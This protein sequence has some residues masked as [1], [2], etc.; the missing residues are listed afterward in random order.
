MPLPRLRRL[1]RRNDDRTLR[2][3]PPQRTSL[4][5]RILAQSLLLTAFTV[6]TLSLLSVIVMH[7]MTRNRALAQLSSDVVTREMLLSRAIQFDRERTA[8]LTNRLQ[9]S[10]A[11]DVASLRGLFEELVRE[12]VPVL[13]LTIVD[14]TGRALA[15]AGERSAAR[16]AKAQGTSVTPVLDRHG[17]WTATDVYAALPRGGTLAVR[18]ASS[19]LLK[20]L[21]E[22]LAPGDSSELSLLRLEDGVVSKPFI[23]SQRPVGRGDALPLEEYPVPAALHEEAGTYAGNDRFGKQIFAAYRTVPALGWSLFLAIDTSEAMAG[24]ERFA[25]VML[26]LDLFMIALS[27]VLGLALARQLSEPILALAAKMRLLRPGRW[28]FRRSV[29][30]GDEAETLDYAAAELTAR[31]RDTYEHLEEEVSERT[32]ELRRQY[33]LDRTILERIEYAVLVTDAAGSIVQANPAAGRLLVR[34]PADLLGCDAVVALPLRKEEESLGGDAHPIRRALRRKERMLATH[35]DRLSILV[36]GHA[37]PVAVDALPL[38]RGSRFEGMIVIVRDVQ[39][40]KRVEEMK[41]D[42][43][44]LASH[45]LRTPLS[46]LR[47]YVELLRGERKPSLSPVQ[48][49]FVGE[50]E[51]ASQR[52]GE[53]LDEL[54]RITRLE[55]GDVHV[56]QKTFD[57]RALLL[58]LGREWEDLAVRK[59][60]MC[61]IDAPSH[62]VRIHSD[63][64]LLRLV[65]QNLFSNALKYSPNG[66]SIRVQLQ[67][68]AGSVAVSMADAG[69]GIPR[70]EQANVFRKFFRAK[71]ARRA[72][73][74]GTGIGLYLTRTIVENLGGKISFDS[75]GKGTT[76]TVKLPLKG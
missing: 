47:W 52:M 59:G 44:S 56:E 72:D 71:N 58:S 46:S 36:D 15:G 26:A 24:W 63:P 14:E 11:Q 20:D 64:V 12:G 3:F 55:A 41:S 18:Y 62:A 53:L 50:I 38:L 30:T 40:E 69:M 7:A 66:S 19:P 42:F 22:H 13:G 16:A 31:L 65:L 37:V 45:Q 67:R 43:I 25:A 10:S 1:L 33:L 32:E 48:R 6:L 35:N 76:F 4:R 74:S 27:V 8:F 29:R 23:A 57:L 51:R 61:S 68:R 9:A 2:H 70:Q 75:S 5:R 49:S 17:S 21:S 28:D 34:A 73:A 60:L 39:E 54:L